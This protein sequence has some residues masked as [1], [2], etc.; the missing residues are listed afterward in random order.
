MVHEPLW[1]QFVA[2]SA[3]IGA[4]SPFVSAFFLQWHWP[5]WL[6]T[7]VGVAIS[8]AAAITASV[9]RDAPP[10][11]VEDWCLLAV[12]VIGSTQIFYHAL[13]KKAGMPTLER[14]TTLHFGKPGTHAAGK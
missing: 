3:A 4:L 1:V 6:K 14:K 11:T 13:W 2:I 8:L 5:K 10:H 12:S 9:V 7:L